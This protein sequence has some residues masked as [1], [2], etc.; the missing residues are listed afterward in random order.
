MSSL[1]NDLSTWAAKARAQG[2]RVIVIDID[3]ADKIA[4]ALRPSDPGDRPLC[5]YPQCGAGHPLACKCR[6][7]SSEN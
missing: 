4:E 1:H 2:R 7:A 6:S 3:T 5:T